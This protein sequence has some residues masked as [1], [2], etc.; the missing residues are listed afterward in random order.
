M[1]DWLVNVFLGFGVL[2]LVVGVLSAILRL[3][4]ALSGAT[5]EGTVVGQKESTSPPTSGSSGRP[6]TKLYA[7][8]VEFA[9]DG[10]RYRFTSSL[11]TDTKL[12]QGSKVR[13]RYLPASPDGSA[14]IAGGARMWGYPVMMLA[15]GALFAGFALYAKRNLLG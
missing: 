7:P 8:I 11:A 6:W 9:H 15:A 14:E 2:G 12:A 10:K 1:D 5:A 13:V 4:L 3:R